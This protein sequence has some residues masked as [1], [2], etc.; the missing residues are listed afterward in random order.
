MSLEILENPSVQEQSCNAQEVLER[1]VM[2]LV[3][4]TSMAMKIMI[5]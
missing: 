2:I 3:T 5:W 4:K 1:I